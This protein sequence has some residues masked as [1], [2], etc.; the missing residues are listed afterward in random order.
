MSKQSKRLAARLQKLFASAAVLFISILPVLVTGMWIWEVIASSDSRQVYSAEEVQSFKQYA[1]E[2]GA[3]LRPFEEPIISVTFDDGWESVYKNGF[4][5]LEKYCIKTTQYILGDHFGHSAYLSEDQAKSLFSHGH[6]FAS[7]G[8][9]HPNLVMLD[10]SALIRELEM[11]QRL[12]NKKFG[13]I[14]DFAAPLGSF[15]DPVIESI[16]KYYRSNR[17]TAVDPLTVGDE[18]INLSDSFDYYNINAYTVRSTTTLDDIK[19]LIE[20]TKERNGW[21]VLNYHQVDDSGSYYAVTPEMLED[22]LLAIKDGQIRSATM[23]QVLDAIDAQRRE[24]M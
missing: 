5:L 6:E 16:K 3:D 20:H 12:L 7:H 4:P 8:M 2:Q 23:G 1:C 13:N 19:R 10:S 15:N 9:E 14:S 17:N 18:D 22:H 24:G 21:L 11:S